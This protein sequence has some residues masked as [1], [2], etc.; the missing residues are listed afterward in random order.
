VP[1]VKGL[2]FLAEN[3]VPGVGRAGVVGA[4]QVK[5]VRL[6]LGAGLQGDSAAEEDRA[7]SGV[8]AMAWVYLNLFTK[9]M[10]RSR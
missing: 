3:G 4:E 7:L 2:F 5:A 6:A 10:R 8:N 9:P 1:R